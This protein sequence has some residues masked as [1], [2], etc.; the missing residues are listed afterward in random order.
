MIRKFGNHLRRRPI[1]LI[2]ILIAASANPVFAQC[3]AKDSLWR[4]IIY[5]RDSSEVPLRDQQEQL[6][7]LLDKMK[8]CPYRNDSTHALLLQRVGALHFL[9]KDFVGGIY[10]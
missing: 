7:P 10:Y 1:F 2:W 3:P 9:Q 6:M 5:L 4:R 8:N